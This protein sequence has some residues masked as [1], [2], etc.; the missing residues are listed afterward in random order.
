MDSPETIA[1]TALKRLLRGDPKRDTAFTRSLR[2]SIEVA[3]E[4]SLLTDEGRGVALSLLLDI[5]DEGQNKARPELSIDESWRPDI[6]CEPRKLSARDLAANSRLSKAG[7]TFFYMER[8]ESAPG[9]N[10]AIW[11]SAITRPPKPFRRMFFADPRHLGLT[12]LGPFHLVIEAG[13]RELVYVRSGQIQYHDSRQWPKEVRDILYRRSM[14]GDTAIG[15][16]DY[17]IQHA[18]EKIGRAMW[19]SGTG[20]IL[21]IH[22]PDESIHSKDGDWSLNDE[23]LDIAGLFFDEYATGQMQARCEYEEDEKGALEHIDSTKNAEIAAQNGLADLTRFTQLDGAVM[24]RS[25]LTLAGFGRKLEFPDGKQP[26]YVKTDEITGS[27]GKVHSLGGTRHKSAAHWVA[28]VPGRLALVA[29]QDR[30]LGWV[31]KV[32]Q[33]EDTVE[34]WP[35]RPRLF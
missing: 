17:I 26:S 21:A 11:V 14:N 16:P 28:E 31:F 4:A 13:G 34:F 24:L 6:R 8:A 10:S 7:T 12:V 33:E 32:T 18:L 30:K 19:L 2:A 1:D 23:P 29:S 25:D 22:A 3:I 5:D 20:G 15:T 9:D 27:R 35:W